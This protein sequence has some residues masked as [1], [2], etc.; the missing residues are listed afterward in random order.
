MLL[1][2][3]KQQI[4]SYA[5]INTEVACE[6]NPFV[7][8]VVTPIIKRSLSLPTSQEITFFDSIS[9]CDSES[10]SVM[11]MLASCAAGAVLVEIFIAKGQ[12]EDSYKQGFTLVLNILKEL[13]FH[14]HT[15][16]ITADLNIEVSALKKIWPESQHYL[17]IFHV[18][19]ALWRWL[20]DSK[21]GIPNNYRRQLVS[22]FQKIMYAETPT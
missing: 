2:K 5:N 16:F 6:E 7:V 8:A 9:S 12:T 20:W 17:C 13:V 10:H 11:F 21:N 3:L 18:G 14:R 22:Q 15:T 4:V 19:Q 1:S